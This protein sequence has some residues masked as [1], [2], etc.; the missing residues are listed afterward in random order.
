MQ[1]SCCAQVD[2]QLVL[3]NLFNRQLG[4]FC[5]FEYFVDIHHQSVHYILEVR[6]VGRQRPVIEV[7]SVRKYPG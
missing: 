3:G 1:C 5:T 7:L 4:R 2:N 6:P